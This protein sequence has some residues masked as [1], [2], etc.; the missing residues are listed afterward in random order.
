[1]TVTEHHLEI[2]SSITDRLLQERPVWGAFIGG[3]FIDV[4][5]ADTFEVLEAA[6]AQPLARV[7]AASD[8][9]VHRAVTDSRRAYE[10]VWRDLSPRERGALL[11]H[12]AV[13]IRDHAE[14]LG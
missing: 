3:E 1:M 11:R 4:G 10:E 6:N 2:D 7:V 13:R 8:E 12:V 5:D 14:E 9:L